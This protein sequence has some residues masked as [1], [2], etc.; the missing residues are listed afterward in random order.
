VDAT[1]LLKWQ[2]EIFKDLAQ[3][4]QVPFRILAFH[5]DPHILRHRILQRKAENNDASDADLDVLDSQMKNQQHLEA[6]EMEFIGSD[7]ES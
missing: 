2:R 6:D 7:T 3:R 5:A 1:C 4:L